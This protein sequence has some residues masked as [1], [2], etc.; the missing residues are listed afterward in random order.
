MHAQDFCRDGRNS[1]SWVKWIEVDNFEIY[2]HL[3][4]ADDIDDNTTVKDVV[5]EL[6]SNIGGVTYLPGLSLAMAQ[7]PDVAL[8]LV[9]ATGTCSGLQRLRLRYAASQEPLD[10]VVGLL[11]YFRHLEELE[12][13]SQQPRRTERHA[14][15]AGAGVRVPA[16]R[17]AGHMRDLR[18][19]LTEH[20]ASALL[21]HGPCGD[22][23]PP[24]P[25]AAG[26]ESLQR[27]G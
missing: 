18:E 24:P 16:A 13:R 4:L 9:A 15:A 23:P 1:F 8:G 12:V 19:P 2:D 6:L 22:P 11:L 21:G 7:Q 10:C 3:N 17:M 5:L 14:S 27:A 25:R 20:A 26:G